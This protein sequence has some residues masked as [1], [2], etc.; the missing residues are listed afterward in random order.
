MMKIVPYTKNWNDG[1]RDWS[2][3]EDP[4]SAIETWENREGVQLPDDYRRFMLKFN[5]GRVYPR[6]FKHNL[7]PINLG[8]F[9]D[10]S[11]E[12][13]VDLIFSWASVESHWRGETYGDGVPPN[14]LVIADDPGGINLLL[15]TATESRG[16]I[17]A[18]PH[19]TDKWGTDRNTKIYTQSES[20]SAFLES[21][22]DDAD[23]SDY[24][25]WKLPI[26]EQL[27]KELEY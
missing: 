26:Y 1:E 7:G 23:Q 22:Y 3:V 18:W 21:L 2:F 24:V 25:D 4:T 27:Q 12:T 19:S 6:K 10:D 16:R 11:G 13:Y 17:F 8:P 14:H 5:G 20:F 9:V 15:S